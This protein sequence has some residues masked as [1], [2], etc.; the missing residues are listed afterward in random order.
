MQL[1][2]T[3][4]ARL[5][6]DQIRERGVR[7]FGASHTR[8]YLFGLTQSMKIISRAPLIARERNEFRLAARIHY[9]KA[10]IIAYRITDERVKIIRVFSKYQ[11]W[12]Q[13]L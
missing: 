1:E 2:I 10:H 9:Y 6:L 13:L 4:F 11:D 3:Y 8:K 7:E 5:D 12:M